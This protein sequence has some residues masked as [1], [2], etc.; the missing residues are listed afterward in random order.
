MLRLHR[1]HIMMYITFRDFPL[2]SMDGTITLPPTF[3]ERRLGLP[4]LPV[5]TGFRPPL[6]KA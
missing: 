4:T 1:S 5:V 3:A 2:Q 6:V